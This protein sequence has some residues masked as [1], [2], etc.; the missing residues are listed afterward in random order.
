VSCAFLTG[1]SV[2]A[3]TSELHGHNSAAFVTLKVAGSNGKGTCKMQMQDDHSIID[4][5]CLPDP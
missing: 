5:V 1:G 2:V 3:A 4:S